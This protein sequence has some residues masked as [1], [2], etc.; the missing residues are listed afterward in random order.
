MIRF[1]RSALALIPLAFILA[2]CNQDPASVGSNLISEQ[3]KFTFQQ[4]DSQTSDIKQSSTYFAFKPK[5]GSASYLLLGKVPYAESSILY[6]WN[7]ILPDSTLQRFGNNEVIVKESWIEMIP[8][9]TL[10]NSSGAFDF[11]VQKV[12]SAWGAPTFDRDSISS[13]QYDPQNLKS[14]MVM[15]D[16]TLKFNVDPNVVKEWLS[17]KYNKLPRNNGILLKATAN[18]QKMIGFKAVQAGSSDYETYMHIVLQRPSYYIDTLV[19]PPD[20]DIHFVTSTLPP[21]GS[22][23]YLQGSYSL[24]GTLYF[25][26]STIPKNSIINKAQLEL[27]VDAAN[28]LYGSLR[29]DSVFVQLLSDSTNKTL[30]D[31]T[32]YALLSRSN[33]VYAGDISKYV[34]RWIT[35]TE[36]QGLDLSLLNEYYTGARIAFYG[37]KNPNKALRPK[38]KIIYMQKN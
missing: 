7:L 17:I 19:V 23:L 15:T 38:L 10:G 24:R 27:T 21:A 26:V 31:S 28:E 37:S 12:T 3:D 20:E 13:L 5:L 16:T 29:S 8:R 4:L 14:N 35:G 33:N 32:S 6:R 2:S 22:D 30:F 1:F 9:N 25:D 18:T 34:Q 36:N 11:T